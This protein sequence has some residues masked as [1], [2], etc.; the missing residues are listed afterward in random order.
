[1]RRVLVVMAL[2]WLVS[3]AAQADGNVEAGRAF[4]MEN[5]SRCHAVEATG[6]SPRADAPRFRN[7]QTMW[8]LESLEEALGEGIV[9][10]H[11]DMP[12]FELDGQ[13]INDLLAYLASLPAD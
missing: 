8:P 2:S 3:G 6:E 5:C 13:Q 12:Q 9:V 4:A 1:M 7:F 11:P 10:G